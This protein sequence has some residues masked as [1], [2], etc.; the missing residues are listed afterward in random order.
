MIS[1]LRISHRVNL[2]FQTFLHQPLLQT[3]HRPQPTIS[4]FQIFPNQQ[5]QEAHLRSS[6][7]LHRWNQIFPQRMKPWKRLQHRKS[8]NLKKAT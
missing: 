8:R 2:V 5:L 3:F 6:R 7:L 1:R 4:G